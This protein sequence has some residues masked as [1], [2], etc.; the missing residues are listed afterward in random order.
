MIEQ[1]IPLPSKVGGS[2]SPRCV[3][4]FFLPAPRKQFDIIDAAVDGSSLGFG[5]GDGFVY[6]IV[7]LELRPNVQRAWEGEIKKYACTYTVCVKALEVMF[8][9][10]V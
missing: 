2:A 7:L 3:D 1:E 4:A 5:I 6:N 9:T 8:V 10:A